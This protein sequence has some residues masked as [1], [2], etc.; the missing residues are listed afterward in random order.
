MTEKQ[1]ISENELNPTAEQG[2][3]HKGRTFAMAMQRRKWSILVIT[4]VFIVAAIIY[5]AKAV[6]TYTSTARLYIEQTG[7]RIITDYEGVMTQSKN[8]LYTQGELIKSTPIIAKVVSD[9]EIRKLK[10]LK[11]QPVS[12][13][14][15]LKGK[16]GLS[17]LLIETGE[18]DNQVIYLKKI[19]DVKIGIKDD[20]IAVSC[21]SPY[22]EEAAKIVNAVVDA[23]VDYQTNQKKSTVSEVLR[24]LQK[25]KIERDKELDRNFEELL[26]FTREHGVVSLE[27]SHGN[28]LFARLSDLSNSFAEAQLETINAKAELEAVQKLGAEPIRIKQYALAQPRTGVTIFASDRENELYLELKELK[29]ELADALLQCS[30]DHPTV[31]ALKAKIGQTE[32]ELSA[33]VEEFARAYLDILKIGYE[34]AQQKESELAV[35]YEQERKAAQNLNVKATEYS[36]LESKL[37][38]SKRFC[39]ILDDR[40]KELNVSEDAGALN[41]SILE[42]ARPADLATSP[43]K[44][45]IMAVNLILGILFGIGFAV[46]REWMDWRLRGTE[47]ISALLA[48]PVL[49][50]V[51]SM[52]GKKGK[53]KQAVANNGQ[54]VQLEPKSSVAEAYRTIRTAVFFGVPKGQARTILVTSPAPS[55]GKTTMVSNLAISM[56]QAGQKTLIID[57]DFRKPMQHNVFGFTNETENGLSSVLTGQVSLEQAIRECPTDGLY[58]L[59]SGPDVPNPSELLNSEA[60]ENLLK[61]LTHHYDRIVVDSPPVTSVADSQILAAICDVTILVLRAEISTRKASEH[62]KEALVSVGAHVLGVVVNDVSPKHSRYGYYSHYGYYGYGYGQAKKNK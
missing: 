40:I 14:D 48:M 11:E 31:K 47:E 4:I 45:R 30:E 51:P 41:V 36:I 9:A 54:K 5:I 8:Y 13:I 32:Q 61:E 17:D 1:K 60:F 23:Y 53:G 50:T 55:D 10:T 43:K 29:A 27:K 24:I 46:T 58:L 16:I 62:A 42:G 57:A 25:E 19:I 22:R 39:E 18:I 59:T 38:Q 6:P 34:S 35:S 21:V 7:P 37:E 20:I 33:M 56:A 52:T 3:Q 12:F 2:S 49:G 26:S 44:A 28:L 15:N